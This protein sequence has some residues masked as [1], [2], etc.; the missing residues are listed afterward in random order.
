MCFFLFSIDFLYFF[1]FSIS[2]S[3]FTTGFSVPK[4]IISYFNRSTDSLIKPTIIF[5]IFR[6][7][8]ANKFGKSRIAEMP[9]RQK[10][11]NLR[12]MESSG[13]SKR[14]HV[15]TIKVTKYFHQPCSSSCWASGFDTAS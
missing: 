12:L 8:L 15:N 11:S 4:L 3:I 1:S 6:E 5:A 14:R 2:C 13:L 9:I 10:C 7:V